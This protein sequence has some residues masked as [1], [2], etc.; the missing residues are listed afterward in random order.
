MLLVNKLSI[1]DLTAEDAE[2]FPYFPRPEEDIWKTEVI[3]CF[4]E[5]KEHGNLDS[6]YLELINYLSEN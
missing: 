2:Y 1:V 5:E 6:S 3:Q 4:L